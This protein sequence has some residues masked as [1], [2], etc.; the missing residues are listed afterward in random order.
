[1]KGQSRDMSNIDHKTQNENKQ[2]N[3]YN[4]EN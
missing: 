4:T 2:S 3:K 1:M